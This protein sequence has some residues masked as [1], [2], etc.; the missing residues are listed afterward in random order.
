MAFAHAFVYGVIQQTL[1]VT[2]WVPGPVL[3]PWDTQ[4]T[5]TEAH[6]SESYQSRGLDGHRSLWQQGHSTDIYCGSAACLGL[7]LWLSW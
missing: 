7:P 1:I 4:M 3:G 2:F 5:R 6:L